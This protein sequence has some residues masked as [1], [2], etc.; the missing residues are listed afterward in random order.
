L[1]HFAECHYPVCHYPVCHCPECHYPESHYRECHYPQCYNG[2]YSYTLHVVMLS[3]MAPSAESM[4]DCLQA[5][6]QFILLPLY[7]T[8][9]NC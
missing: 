2:E 6:L 1:C 4:G 7:V 8:A 3:V 5:P 9:V